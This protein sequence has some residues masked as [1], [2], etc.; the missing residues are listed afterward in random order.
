M[1]RNFVI[2]STLF[3]F[4]SHL[5]AN[6]HINNYE[7][8][9]LIEKTPDGQACINYLKAGGSFTRK[10]QR[11]ANTLAFLTGGGSTLGAILTAPTIIGPFLFTVYGGS[12]ASLSTALA[13]D[14]YESKKESKKLGLFIEE[15]YE[16]Y[17]TGKM[18]DRSYLRGSMHWLKEKYPATYL[19]ESDVAYTVV[20]A[21]EAGWFCR[22][23]VF[24]KN[25]KHPV[26]YYVG[27]L[28]KKWIT[29]VLSTLFYNGFVRG[30]KMDSIEKFQ[31]RN[32]SK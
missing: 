11:K 24:D 30:P 31:K 26:S 16:F 18:R 32:V 15:A 19:N 4:S 13:V 10:K 5:L 29:D 1:L 2:Y 23:K 8:H 7:D 6:N 12:A 9:P 27:S 17:Q 22:A 21:N 28:E 20:R 25:K 14:I 3:F